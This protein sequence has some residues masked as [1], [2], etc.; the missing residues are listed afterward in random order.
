[1]EKIQNNIE[2]SKS[3]NQSGIVLKPSLTLECLDPKFGAIILDSCSRFSQETKNI[4]SQA[5]IDS[6][7]TIL[8]SNLPK[9]VYEKIKDISSEDI[10]KIMSAIVLSALLIAT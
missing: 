9:E 4:M 1:M 8:Q 3:E 2:F 10:V 7:Q 6:F 5:D